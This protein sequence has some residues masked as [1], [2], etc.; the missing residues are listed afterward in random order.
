[1][2]KEREEI[3]VTLI[4]DTAKQIINI[5]QIM[6]VKNLKHILLTLTWIIY[7]DMQWVNIYHMLILNGLKI[8]KNR[9]KI[10]EYKK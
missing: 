10:N 9:T 6:T 8:L 4:K 3:L 5:A 2:K 1:M 7:M